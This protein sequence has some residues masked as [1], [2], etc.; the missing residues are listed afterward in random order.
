MDQLI[1]DIVKE[2]TKEEKKLMRKHSINK[3]NW[4]KNKKEEGLS[5]R[6]DIC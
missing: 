5:V 2:T 1:N 3:D 6:Q 4:Q